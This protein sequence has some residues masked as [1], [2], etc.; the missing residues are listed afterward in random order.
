M[1]AAPAPDVGE[2]IRQYRAQLGWG[3]LVVLGL[4]L[5]R[6]SVLLQKSGEGFEF[7]NVLTIVALLVAWFLLTSYVAYRGAPLH[8]AVGIGAAPS[9]ARSV[10]GLLETASNYAAAGHDFW[11][12]V[13]TGDGQ[14]IAAVG[15]KVGSLFLVGIPLALFA[16]VIGCESARYLREWR[17]EGTSRALSILLVGLALLSMYVGYYLGKT[18]SPNV[19]YP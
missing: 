7:H 13:V 1:T 9:G 14:A 8:W 3:C 15:L 19:L 10:T 11:W 12:L 5:P 17:A 6:L 2:S 16:Y 4:A 18:T